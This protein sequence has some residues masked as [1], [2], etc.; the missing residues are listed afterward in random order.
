M[1]QEND[2]I[3]TCFPAGAPCLLCIV[4]HKSCSCNNVRS[5]F[6]LTWVGC[7][8]CKTS[9]PRWSALPCFHGLDPESS[10]VRKTHN[11]EMICRIQI[12]V[13]FTMWTGNV[14]KKLSYLHST[15]DT[16]QIMKVFPD[17]SNDSWKG[18]PQ[19]LLHIGG[20]GCIS[21]ICLQVINP[22]EKEKKKR[23]IL[24]S[25]SQKTGLQKTTTC[26]SH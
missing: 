12:Y 23:F 24:S 7:C 2:Q 10:P 4:K 13:G 3:W 25:L 21:A 1:A 22:L 8:C 15:C 17:L 20:P 6:R 26:S 19:Q 18:G 11:S 5:I 9:Q 14:W 16:Y